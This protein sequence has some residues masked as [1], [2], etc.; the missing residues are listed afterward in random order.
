VNEQKEILA[1][2][3][4]KLDEKESKFNENVSDEVGYIRDKL[5]KKYS[6]S[7]QFVC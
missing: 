7:K 3:E 4:K 5:E 1:S 2:R 6:K